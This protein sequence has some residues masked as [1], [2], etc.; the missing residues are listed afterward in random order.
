MSTGLLEATGL[1]STEDDAS[2]PPIGGQ[3]L[4]V[5]RAARAD[6]ERDTLVDPSDVD[7]GVVDLRG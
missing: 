7:G 3:R 6:C 5:L 2:L 1:Q 4:A